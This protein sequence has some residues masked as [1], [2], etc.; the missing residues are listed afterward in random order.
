M[1]QN[2]ICPSECAS[3]SLSTACLLASTL[4]GADHNG[5][6]HR[7]KD[8][9]DLIL[10]EIESN[11]NG[12]SKDKRSPQ[13]ESSQAVYGAS[14]GQFVVRTNSP[15]VGPQPEVPPDYLSLLQ[16]LVAQEQQDGTQPPSQPV[17]QQLLVAR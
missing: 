12:N 1:S 9:K 2:C 3:F 16:Q 10:L 11:A 4:V 7:E 13:H 17:I 8:R 15:S 6:E 14:P 5:A